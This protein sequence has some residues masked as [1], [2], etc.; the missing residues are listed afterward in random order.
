MKF[1]AVA[2]A[3]AAFTASA[4]SQSL[5]G[6]PSCA[7]SCATNSIPSD[8]GID[9]KCIC[10]AQSFITGVSCCVAKSCNA[11]DQE[12]T[13]KY[14]DKICAGAGV[15]NLPTS[16]VCSST[17]SATG[18]SQTSSAGGSQTA[19]TATATGTS[20]GASSTTGSSSA[21][22]ASPSGTN[23]ATSFSK[24]DG[25]VTAG[26]MAAAVFAAMCLA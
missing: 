2:F 11:E 20:T 24:A 6:L 10:N 21:T 25:R 12:T 5:S 1:T 17:A 22:A 18:G 26:V 13:I 4:A 7:I 8:C 15:T 14:A 23:A 3:I 9:V 16:A 19:A